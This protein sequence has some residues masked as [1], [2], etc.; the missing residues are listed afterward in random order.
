MDKNT[1]ANDHQQLGAAVHTDE[2]RQHERHKYLIPAEA[3]IVDEQAQEVINRAQIHVRDVSRGG[4]RALSAEPWTVNTMI[5]VSWV[6]Q[7]GTRTLTCCRI[8][9]QR[10]AENGWYVLG[11]SF[12]QPPQRLMSHTWLVLIDEAMNNLMKRKPAA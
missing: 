8:R 4:V 7:D 2:R 3:L 10:Q 12:E 11:L 1:S 5:V 9:N 6:C